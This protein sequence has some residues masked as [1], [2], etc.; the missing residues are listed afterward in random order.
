MGHRPTVVKSMRNALIRR[1]RSVESDPA[2]R[3]RDGLY[4]AWGLHLA[5]E[6]LTTGAPIRVAILTPALE[7]AP[8]G[9][10][11]GRRLQQLGTRSIRATSAVLDGIVP[12]S[13]DQGVLLLIEQRCGLLAQLICK[14][15]HLVVA[16]HGV[17]DPGN[18][19]SIARTALALGA[20]GLIVLEGCADP[21][22]SRVVRAAMGA[23]FRL[24]IVR[25]T[26]SSC[27]EALR[28][29]GMR[30]VA[31]DARGSEMPDQVDLRAPL[32]LFLGNEGR[33]LPEPILAT[34]DHRVRIPMQPEVSSLNVHAAAAMLLYEAARQRRLG[35]YG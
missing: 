21:Y 24:P 22:G 5:Q 15:T 20:Q 25:G 27:L 13:A 9:R 34:A 23:H 33:G 35:S 12:G 29:R 18:L 6:A 14:E 26:A 28:G 17:Q 10:R 4:V 30:I 8:E 3:R 31:A 32:A 11:I 1:A 7:G 16:T 19:G 2:V